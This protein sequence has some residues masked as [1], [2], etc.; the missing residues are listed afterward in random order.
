[1]KKLLSILLVL[2]LSV[3]LLSGCKGTDNQGETDKSGGDIKSSEVIQNSDHSN[4]EDAENTNITSTNDAPVDAAFSQADEDMFTD[5]DKRTEYDENDSVLIQLN[6]TSA[7]AS[8]D[9]MV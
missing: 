3:C 4:T 8:S 7:A 9:R 6:G 1:M 5:R 2:S